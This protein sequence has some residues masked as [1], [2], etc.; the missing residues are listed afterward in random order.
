MTNIYTGGPLDPHSRE[1]AASSNFKASQTV[2]FGTHL[3]VQ[4]MEC[5]DTM[6]TKQVRF[7]VYVI[8]IPSMSIMICMADVQQ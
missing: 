2:P 4:V 7:I 1:N 6:P 8:A 5:Q 3:V